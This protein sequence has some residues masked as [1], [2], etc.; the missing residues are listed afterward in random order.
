MGIERVQQ[1]GF[2]WRRD[3]PDSR[4]KLAAKHTEIFTPDTPLP[5]SVDLSPNFSPVRNQGNL[6]ACTGFSH[7]SAVEYLYRVDENPHL[8]TIYSP[9][10]MYYMA[11]EL[12]GTIREDAGAYIRTGAKLLKNVGIAPENRHPYSDNYNRLT[13]QPTLTAQKEASRWRVGPYYRCKGVDEL[14]R[15]LAN[16]FAVVG[17]FSCF[18]NMFTPD[19]DESG[20]IP[21][22]GGAL[23]G[24]HAV[25]FSGYDDGERRFRFKNSW[26]KGWGDNG[27]GTLPYQ[28]I[29]MGLAADFWCYEK[30]SDETVHPK[31]DA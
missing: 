14:R 12:E 1:A 10:F 13:K 21:M 25:H 24:G 26:S 16:R 20:H 7:A 11:R 15:A 9:L 8:S 6:G 5:S 28:F 22:P 29:E 2:G 4:D 31:R 27:Y 3:L 30:E 18:N 17:G 19:I 23:V